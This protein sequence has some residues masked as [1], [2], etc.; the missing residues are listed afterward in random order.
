MTADKKSPG[1]KKRPGVEQ[2]RKIILNAAIDLF[3]RQRIEATSVS[4]IC[5]RANVSRDTFYRCFKDRDALIDH[6][7]QTAVNDHVEQ[8]MAMSDLDYSN[9]DWVK[10][11][12]ATAIDG[13]L[14]DHKI[15]RFLFVESADPRSHTHELVIRALE[16]VAKRMQA[17]CRDTHGEA[18]S[19][20]YLL[21]ILMASQWLVHN[22]I[23][24]GMT[25]DEIEKAKEASSRLFYTAL[26]AKAK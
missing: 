17:W 22:A 6:F 10:Q 25:P 5:Q 26:S 13:I 20:E 12:S 2:Q 1:T 9:P 16:N 21:S 18:P 14:K 3:S 8:I 23:N 15:A 24:N 4:Q 19:L 11:A 7:Y